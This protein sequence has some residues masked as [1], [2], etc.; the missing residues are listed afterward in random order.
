MV[1]DSVVDLEGVD[2]DKEKKGSIP[3]LKERVEDKEDQEVP[4][5]KVMALAKKVKKERVVKKEEEGSTDDFSDDED[6]E[7][8]L[9]LKEVVVREA[10]MVK[11]VETMVSLMV[12]REKIALD[13]RIDHLD[14]D[15]KEE[16][17]AVR[18]KE[19]SE[20][21]SNVLEEAEVVEIVDEVVVE[22]VDLVAEAVKKV[23][24]EK[25]KLNR[26]VIFGHRSFSKLPF[27]RMVRIPF[28]RL[29]WRNDNN[30]ESRTKG[31][32]CVASIR[33]LPFRPIITN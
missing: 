24:E 25:E 2:D 7:Q 12:E 3:L 5:L 22:I 28:K 19:V 1:G 6:L 10:R 26:Y 30:L 8:G 14:H 4:E 17:A 21:A 27:H 29:S 33:V 13:D 18:V 16:V 15:V 11:Q 20:M 9:V 31:S 32:L 23:V